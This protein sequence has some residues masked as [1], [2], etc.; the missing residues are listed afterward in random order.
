MGRPGDTITFLVDG[1]LVAVQALALDGVPVPAGTAL[2]WPG[3]GRR[4]Q[5]A[6]GAPADLAVSKQAEPV[7]AG[8]GSIV[9][10]TLSTTTPAACRLRAG[11]SPTP[12]RP[13]WLWWPSPAGRR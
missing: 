13:S 11:Q 12:S 1:A 5:A 10:Y 7:S 8:F 3:H 9:T 6:L 4:W 2:V